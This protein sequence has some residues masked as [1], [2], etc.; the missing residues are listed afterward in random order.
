MQ[1]ILLIGAGAIA[2]YHRQ[3]LETYF[4][5]GN[6]HL[7]VADQNPSALTT[8]CEKALSATRF[9]SSAEILGQPCGNNDIVI[10]ATPPFTHH[11]LVMEALR[12]GRHVLCEKPFA[13]D[14]EQAEEMLAEADRLGLML[15]DCSIRFLGWQVSRHIRETIESGQLGD[16][17]QVR[18]QNRQQ[19]SRFAIDAQ[20]G[21]YWALNKKQNGGG[22]L[23]DWG[24][25]DFLLL[26]EILNPV[27][28]EIVSAWIRQPEAGPELP[29]NVVF[30]VEEAVGACLRYQSANGQI[31]HVVFERTACT[32]GE[33]FSIAAIEGTKGALRWD[34]YMFG[35][36]AHAHH[37]FDNGGKLETNTQKF[38]AIN[39]V[40]NWIPKPIQWFSERV[41][42]HSVGLQHSDILFN[43]RC[44]RGIYQCAAEGQP[45]VIR[46]KNSAQ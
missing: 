14:V 39:E 4:G 10:I 37:S 45:V 8:F 29:A 18:W 3:G 24:P 13:L 31:Y 6:Y 20:P 17:Y 11:A 40:A 9:S 5:S 15:G 23:M 7:S 41:N 1:N 30:D 2:E 35:D 21:A 38:Q 34:G 22:C 32:H 36:E 27:E 16:I 28:V 43:F 46:R 19:R 44:L 42:G 26:N 33:E 25:Y 12:S